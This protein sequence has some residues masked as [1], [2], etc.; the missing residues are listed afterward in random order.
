MD[1]D[2]DQGIIYPKQPQQDEGIVYP[3]AVSTIPQKPIE[4][5]GPRQP[6]KVASP[7][8]DPMWLNVLNKV[9]PDW[10]IRTGEKIG[11]IGEA[12]AGG[13]PSARETQRVGPITPL[14]PEMSGATSPP[15]RFG[16]GA[17]NNFIRP[18]SSPLGLASTI[19]MG[20]GG[21]A[22]G[23]SGKV[24]EG[25]AKEIAGEAAPTVAKEGVP[26]AEKVAEQ[27]IK[28]K[29]DLGPFPPIPERTPNIFGTSNEAPKPPIEVAAAKTPA[30]SL[31]EAAIL[32]PP[33]GARGGRGVSSIRAELGSVDKTLMSR[34]ETAPIA[35][36]ITQA[37]DKKLNWIAATERD[38]AKATQGLNK[39]QRITLGKMLDTGKYELDPTL[40]NRAVMIKEQLDK[41]HTM[42]PG[43]IMEGG[44][45]VGFIENYLTHIRKSQLEPE[46]VDGIDQIWKY[47][48]G[49]PLSQMFSAG[50]MQKTAGTSV[51]DMFRRGI[52]NPSSPFGLERTG[53]LASVEY[54]INKV[55][56]AY[57]ESI[58]K[59][60]F[61][62]TAVK[63]AKDVL[64]RLPDKMAD[65]SP[66]TL[67]DLGKWYLTNYTRYDALPGLTQ[68]WNAWSSRLM[69]TTARSMLGFSTG[70]QML[71]LARIP[72]NLYPEIPTKYLAYG[73]SQVAKKPLASWGEA[74]RL[75][76]LQ[77]EIRPMQFKTTSQ[78]IDS[79]IQLGSVADYLD[80]AIGYHGFK[81]MYIDQGMTEA[82]AGLK[83]VGSSKRASLMTDPSRPI[84]AFNPENSLGGSAI[85]MTG[86]FKQVPVKIIEQYMQIAAKAKQDPK[87]A[88]RMIAGVGLAVGAY[89][90]GL[91]TWH[92]GPSS[93]IS[94]LGGAFGTVAKKV[95]G[96][97][98]KGDW[99][100]AL[101]ETVL[102]AI[103]GG[104]SIR[105]QLKSG[106]S[107][108][109]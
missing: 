20:V 65:G 98:A 100:T 107:M 14:L 4:F 32:P 47:H 73:V 58:A 78:K 15:G 82:A 59:L 108:F 74:A 101:T 38:L 83:A 27:T 55:L 93:F 91:K 96:A 109:E 42:I 1:E 25:V 88:A 70:L 84:K 31:E 71:H 30:K 85:R 106:L 26:I 35:E 69:R 11:M 12:L 3:K 95:W 66:N 61:D 72:A 54:D 2:Q 16:Q 51:G 97:L 34:P 87:A 86:Q 7:P 6:I 24:A 45:D 36:G 50:K 21:A 49:K 104:Y 13:D 102:W 60:I 105:R 92:V 19:A 44:A 63:N 56:P 68:A 5:V 9:M 23:R 62:R 53:Q 10:S 103:P 99:E 41:I 43:G 28:P 18:L 39:Q 94:E 57:T 89:E 90:A 48:V 46:L 17:Y 77:N 64:A 37:F 75:G 67:K 40:S 79:L 80:R 76:L 29:P 8:P 52:G 33:G 22:K 81:K